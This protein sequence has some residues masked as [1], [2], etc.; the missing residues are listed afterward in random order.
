VPYLIPGLG[1]AMVALR[2]VAWWSQVTRTSRDASAAAAVAVPARDQRTG[3][4]SEDAARR[5]LSEAGLPVI[6]AR[7]VTS[8]ADA[9]KAA[10]GI[11][12]PVAVKVVSPGIV[13]KSD[14]GAVRLHVPADEDAVREAYGVVTAAAAA[15]GGG[16]VEGA[17][18]SPM[19]SGGAELLV[20]VVRDPDWGPILAVAI[21]GVFVEVLQDSA[22]APLPITPAQAGRLLEKLRGRAVLEGI[23]G[24]VPADLGALAAVIA[25]IGDLAVALGED[26]ESLEVNP[27]RVD[28]TTIEALDAVVTWT[29]KGQ[30]A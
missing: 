8:A 30:D 14:I 10:A 26:L 3:E 1:Q 15:A 20:G 5:L 13:H 12:A 25:R 9:V 17:L 22:L 28:G 27:L 4:W 2:N 11:G 7:L 29:R 18:I 6:P 23:R 21:G 16:P 19:R 24:A